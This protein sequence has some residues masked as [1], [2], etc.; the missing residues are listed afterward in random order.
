LTL[1]IKSQ[2]VKIKFYKAKITEPVQQGQLTCHP[3]SSEKQLN[4]TFKNNGMHIT[5]S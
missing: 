4:T 1:L 5:G 2:I 3:Y